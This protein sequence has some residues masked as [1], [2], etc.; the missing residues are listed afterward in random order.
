M[1]HVQIEILLPVE[2]E[3]LLH[4]R[5]RHPP[6]RRLPAPPVEQSVVSLFDVALSPAPHVPVADPKD[7]RRLPPGD[8]LGHRLQ[9]HVLY[10]HRPLHR[11]LRVTI[12]ASHGLL[13]SPPAKRTYHLL[14]QPD[15][16][17]ATDNQGILPLTGQTDGAKVLPLKVVR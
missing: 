8:L 11:G 6:S 4:R 7:L 15:I 14:S 3:Y 9:H 10:F 13:P 5:H 1:L 12:H 2:R 17:C 16:S